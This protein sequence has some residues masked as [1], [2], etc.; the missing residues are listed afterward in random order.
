MMKRNNNLDIECAGKGDYVK[1]DGK[2]FKSITIEEQ[3]RLMLDMLKY[4]D[5]ICRKNNIKYSLIGGSLI[6][7]IRHHGYIPWDDDI[8]IILTRSNYEK[9][10]KILDKET[11]RYQTLKYGQ[12]GKC[13]TFMKLIDTKTGVK[14]CVQKE[15]NPNYGV[16]VDIFCFYYFANNE[17]ERKEQFKKA[18]FYRRMIARNKL[19]LRIRNP[20]RILSQLKRN[21]ISK[22]YNQDRAQKNYAKIVNKYLNS[23]YVVNNWPIYGYEKEII[24]KKDTE[25][26][27]DVVF[28]DLRVMIFKNYDNIL[29]VTYGDY[30]KLPPKSNRLP[31]HNIIAWWRSYDK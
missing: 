12:G 27:I 8:D 26:Y 29:R 11:G 9:L 7:A 17:R 1:I 4:I 18:E 20:K 6:G 25:D 14:E 23:N 19:N 24:L 22:F 30:M 13:F 10:K 31:K 5:E 2:T 21:I 28:E 16:F 15:F 3:K